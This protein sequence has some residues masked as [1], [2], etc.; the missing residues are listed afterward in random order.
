M[1]GYGPYFVDL[2]YSLLGSILRIPKVDLSNEESFEAFNYYR[3]PAWKI[4]GVDVPLKSVSEAG[5]NSLYA[6]RY[7]WDDTDDM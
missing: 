6:Y 7:D 1:V 4:R 2:D 3:G 5:N